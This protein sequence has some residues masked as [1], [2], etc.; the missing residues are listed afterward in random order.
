VFLSGNGPLGKVLQHSLK[1]KVFV[2]DVHGF[3]KEYGGNNSKLPDEKVIIFDE[4]QRA[5]DAERAMEMRNVAI[6]EPMDFLKIGAKRKEGTLNVGLIGE[7]QEIHLGE[8]GGIKQWDDAIAQS[9]AKWVVHC[10]EK[11]SHHFTSA[12]KV[13]INE[14]LNLTVTLRSHLVE[15]VDKWV[16]AFLEGDF[17]SARQYSINIEKENFNI[18]VTQDVDVA[19]RYAIERYN[20]CEDKRYGLICSAKAKN[21]IPYD[22]DNGFY[23]MQ[24]ISIGSWFNDPPDSVKSCCSLQLPTTEFQCQGLELDLPIVCWG[25]DLFYSKNKW[26]NRGRVRYKSK[27]PFLVTKNCYR[28]LLTRGRDGMIIF[29]PPDGTYDTYDALVNSGAKILYGYESIDAIGEHILAVTAFDIK[30][31]D[32]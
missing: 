22:I 12:K 18:Y 32:V 25:D 9:N 16:E 1:S 28:V 14:S 2:Q 23:S 29:V 10:P 11:I 19:K 8:E 27:N 7:G 24:R 26:E 4:A 15:D 17:K 13:V 6:S 20:A 3:L 31:D 30:R 21:L 5:W